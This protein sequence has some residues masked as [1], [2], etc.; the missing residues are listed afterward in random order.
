MAPLAEKDDVVVIGKVWR[1]DAERPRSPAEAP[2][3][4]PAA[5][6]AA[7]TSRGARPGCG[8]RR[9]AK[10]PR[11]RPGH[12]GRPRVRVPRAA[13]ARQVRPRGKAAGPCPPVARYSLLAPRRRRLPRRRIR[14]R[15]RPRSPTTSGRPRCA[16]RP[17]PRPSRHP[18]CLPGQRTRAPRP[19]PGWGHPTAS[20]RWPCGC[21]PAAVRGPAP[22]RGLAGEGP[23]R[24]L[25][26]PRAARA[27]PAWT[28]PG[29]PAPIPPAR[30]DREKTAG[31]A[32]PAAAPAVPASGDPVPAAGDPVPVAGDPVPVA[33]DSGA[34]DRGFPRGES[35]FAGCG[36]TRPC[37]PLPPGPW[38]VCR[39]RP[40][41]PPEPGVSTARQPARPGSSSAQSAP[42]GPSG[43][44]ARGG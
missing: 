24:A 27:A 5:I 21:G 30:G 6:P 28:P 33:G 18:A 29:P 25:V 13:P 37:P 26:A 19:G 4:A 39:P 43:R 32:V 41:A 20:S 22:G 34:P 23:A 2:A 12:P 1:R 38:W 15:R 8:R 16:P 35:R 17:R 7:R 42:R 44:P 36:R 14:R 3:L 9:P 11:R 10:P 40:A 31:P